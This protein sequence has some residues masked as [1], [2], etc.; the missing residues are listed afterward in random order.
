MEWSGTDS[1]VG[2]QVGILS[3]R[4]L[5]AYRVNPSLVL[6]HA[7]IE[8]ATAQGGYGRRQ[9]YELIQNGADAL[10]GTGT[11]RIQVVLTPTALYCA[12][13][14]SPIDIDGVGALLAS[15]ISMKRGTEIGRFGLGFKSV[16][17]VTR[18]PEFYSRSGSFVFDAIESRRRITEIVTAPDRTP[19][20][21]L[22]RPVDPRQAAATDPVLQ[23]LMTWATTVIKLPGG[24]TVADWLSEDLTAF[25]AEFLLFSPHVSALDLDDRTTGVVRSIAL[26]R[27]GEELELVTAGERSRWRV[28]SR[29]HRPSDAAREDAGELANR[30]TVPIHWA[31]SL[32]S[33]RRDGRFWAFFPTEYL[34]TLSGIINAPWKTNEDRQN[35]LAGPFNDELIRVASAMV[36]E[37]IPSLH[38]TEDPGRYLDLLPARGR[39]TRNWADALVTRTVYAELAG[40]PSIADQSG[41]LRTA[42]QMHL[43]PDRI[44]GKILTQWA[45]VPGRPDDWA[46]PSTAS[47]DDRRSRVE[48]LIVDAG[49]TVSTVSRW[50][51]ALV[52]DLNDPAGSVA[53]V[54]VAAALIAE[55]P[56][57]LSE[58]R[59]A[60][61]VLT[62]DGR[63]MVPNPASVYLPSDIRATA[64]VPVVAEPLLRDAETRAAL[65]QLG[66]VTVDASAEIE[67]LLRGRLDEWSE[68]DWLQFWTR[69]R[70]IDPTVAARVLERSLD[71]RVELRGGSIQTNHRAVAE[72]RVR[73]RSG[74][75][76]P[77]NRTMLSGRVIDPNADRD[78]DVALD[79]TFHGPD[80]ALFRL[81]GMNDVPSLW[82]RPDSEEWFHE[83]RSE[84]VRTFASHLSGRSR[85]DSEYLT[86]SSMETL[87]PLAPLE[88]LSDEGSAAFTHELLLASPTAPQWTMTHLTRA[89]VYPSTPVE[90]PWQWYARRHGW[91]RT[92]LGPRQVGRAVGPALGAFRD[93]LPV[94]ELSAHDAEALQ[95]PASLNELSGTNWEA[96]LEELQQVDDDVVLGKFTAAAA[97]YVAPPAQMRCRVGGA[98][99]MVEPAQ[100]CVTSD[101]SE[102]TALIE[103]ST[104]VL[105]V[106]ESTDRDLLIQEWG[107]QPSESHVS[108]RTVFMPSAAAVPLEDLFPGLRHF[109]ADI[110]RLQVQ[111]CTDLRKELTTESGKTH[112]PVDFL[113]ESGT[114]FAAESLDER[115][116]L[117]RL[118]RALDFPLQPTDV[119]DLLERKTIAQVNRRIVAARQQTSDAARLLSLVGPEALRRSLPEPLINAVQEMHGELDGERL[120][121]I[122][123]AMYGPDALREFRDELRTH[124]FEPP[125]QWAGSPRAVRF[126]RELGFP[127]EFAGVE[128]PNREPNVEIEGPRELPRLHSFQR[129]IAD[130]IRSLLSAN[131]ERRALMSLPTGAGKTRVAVQALVESARDD[132]FQ[133]PI[134]WIADRDELCEQA[135]QAWTEVWRSLGPQRR[136][137]VSRFWSA[138]ETAPVEEAF[139]V[140]VATIAKLSA[141]I[142]E[143]GYAWLADV[144]CVVVDEAHS[145]TSPAYTEVLNL[146]GLGRSQRRDSAALLGLTATPFRGT[147]AEET[148]RLAVRYGQRRLDS[149]VLGAN[150]ELTLQDMGVLARVEQRLLPGEDLQLSPEELRDLSRLR[151]L[152][153]AAEQRLGANTRRNRTLLQSILGLDPTWPVLLFATSV[154]HAQTMAALL[155]LEGV[156]AAAVSAETSPGVRRSY[157]EQFRS[158]RLRVLTNYGVLTQGFDAPSVRAVYIARPTYSP[159]VYQQMIGRGLRGPLNG[160]KD[161]CLIVN[162]QDNILQ[163]GERLAFHD[164]DYLWSREE[165]LRSD[166]P[167]AGTT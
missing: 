64:T 142:N 125:E 62:S 87:G 50:L 141:S 164:F 165:G 95:L 70:T 35:L 143:P 26:S 122:A 127:G 11:G 72:L 14:G 17:G 135:V 24:S 37:E 91:V 38:S 134:L 25:P 8:A 21:R 30:D 28:F 83:Y 78:A 156:P 48:R 13:E 161:E 71:P 147:S 3:E 132:A 27:D 130:R 128:T 152:P 146:V 39:E 61:I 18:H 92:S 120:G 66:L 22:A 159:N 109:H 23:Q 65:E 124:G 15:H 40:R 29:I 131:S 150:P 47:R 34:T 77:I 101:R 133:G 76:R 114:L 153:R 52:E 1:S 82:E 111:F 75:F 140:V 90:P 4:C 117:E 53:A 6:E 7:N 58:V 9:L 44:P 144:S 163:F 99:T 93:V 98:H 59:A 166:P 158:G 16:L 116:L 73:T 154:Q 103:E 19:A 106:P 94:A 45:A 60:A 108:R 69:C 32:G 63:L 102:F 136:L 119:D 2:E 55:M 86:F 67:A 104:P 81:L 5:A 110:S 80:I 113:I 46:H 118:A 155:T 88:A 157:I 121:Q 162:V 105:L 51:R 148:R 107:L 167:E 68:S 126:V 85:P 129:E 100:V 43:S 138:N 56:E 112:E 49:G 74:R 160:G 20:L 79:E 12:N 115:G 10:L 33:A 137:H 151:L 36:A 42:D 89:D 97:E 145:S 84:C 57:T 54:K 139:H 96:A 41:V 149:D 123:L 31:V